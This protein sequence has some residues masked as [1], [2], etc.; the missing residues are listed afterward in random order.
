MKGE[1]VLDVLTMNET[2]L[3]KQE[4]KPAP[5]KRKSAFPEKKARR[6]MAQ[7]SRKRNR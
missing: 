5:S 2:A 6:K 1:V 4:Q 7:A 3:M